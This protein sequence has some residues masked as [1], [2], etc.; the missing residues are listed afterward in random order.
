MMSRIRAKN[1]Q[2]EMTVRRLLHG[3]GLRYRL[4][5]TKMPGRPDLIFRKHRAVVFVNGC[6]WHGH[7]CELFRPPSSNEGYWVG[8]I[9]KNR[10]NDARAR[11]ALATDGWRVLTIWECALRGKGRLPEEVLA[12]VAEEWIRSGFQSAEIRG[13]PGR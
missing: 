5:N 12:D 7:D 11:Y 2:P 9:K 3:R 10:A 6:F 8:K 13:T 4:H 1:T